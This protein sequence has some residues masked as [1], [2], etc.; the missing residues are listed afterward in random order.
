[1]P[2]WVKKKVEHQ[3]IRI[4]VNRRFAGEWGIDRPGIQEKS[5]VIPAEFF[6]HSARTMI[7]FEIPG[8]VS[9]ASLGIGPDVRELGLAVFWF[10]LVPQEHS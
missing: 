4:L 7:T 9:P 3:R 10:S 5:L 1:M 8:A 6:S 2:Y